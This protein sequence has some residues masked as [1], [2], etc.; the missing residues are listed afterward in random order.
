MAVI[1]KGE[2]GI[3]TD[4]Y[5]ELIGKVLSELGENVSYVDSYRKVFAFPK[6]ELVVDA[7]SRETFRLILHGYRHILFWFQGLDPEE[8][9]LVMR[10]RLKLAV[11]NLMEWFDVRHIDF[12]LYVSEAMKRY[13][14][15]KY[16]IAPDES[17]CYCMPCMNTELH[18][19][20]FFAEN[21]YES[22]NFAYV[23]SLSVWQ[24]F[25]ETAELYAKIE[26]AFDQRTRFLVFTGDQDDAEKILKRKG[27]R[28]YTVGFVPN[29]Q[30]PRALAD[31]KYGFIVRKDNI[32]N[33][34]A[35]PTKISTYLSCGVIP[36]YSE[37]LED[38]AAAAKTLTYAIPAGKT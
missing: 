21:K 35:T 31:V 30:L 9:Y 37:C 25:E 27:I 36:I 16:R 17:R 26:K 13:L 6:D 38:F 24:S 12:T 1:V 5:L 22:L 20:A 11:L 19:D 8:N 3:V 10:S 4:T 32:V 34:V 15:Q 18:P 2:N 23:G 33:R 28:N 29:E 7:L 14:T